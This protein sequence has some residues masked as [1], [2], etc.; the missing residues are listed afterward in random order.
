MYLFISLSL[1]WVKYSVILFFVHSSN[2]CINSFSYFFLYFIYSVITR[3]SLLHLVC[4]PP[5]LFLSL[6]LFLLTILFHP[7]S[8]P[9]LPVLPSSQLASLLSFLSPPLPLSLSPGPRASLRYITCNLKNQQRRSIFR[10][11]LCTAL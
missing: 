2:F 3:P 4:L 9:S 6:A 8:L 1:L 10:P 5:S 7:A 11:R